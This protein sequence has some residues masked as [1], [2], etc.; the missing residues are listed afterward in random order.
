MPHIPTLKTMDS[1]EDP[2]EKESLATATF[3]IDEES[4]SGVVIHSKEDL[5]MHCT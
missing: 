4:K 5:L 3:G 1:F 2:I